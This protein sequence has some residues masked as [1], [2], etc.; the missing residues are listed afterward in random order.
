MLDLG[1]VMGHMK[2]ISNYFVVR[3]PAHDQD[4]PADSSGVALYSSRARFLLGAVCGDDV[5]YMMP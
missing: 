3:P 4:R 1:N 5:L 2:C